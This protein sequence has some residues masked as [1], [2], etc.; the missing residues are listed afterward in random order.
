MGRTTCEND[1]RF[2]SSFFFFSRFPVARL[3]KNTNLT[4]HFGLLRQAAKKK[5]K[6]ILIFY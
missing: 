5:I 3:L 1:E 2:L 4:Y 6:K